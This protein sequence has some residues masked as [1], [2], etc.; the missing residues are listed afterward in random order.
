MNLGPRT[1]V[2][3]VAHG[4][5]TNLDELPAFLKAVRQG[6]APSDELVAEVRRRYDRVGGSPLWDVTQA[7]ARALEQRLGVP[8]IA[9][10]RLWHPTMLE[11]AADPRLRDCEQLCVLP[12]APFSAE[13]YCAAAT[14]ALGE[15]RAVLPHLRRLATV[16][17]YGSEPG[18]VNTHAA[19]IESELRRTANPVLVAS[20]HSVPESW[21]ETALSYQRRV[22]DCGEAIGARLGLRPLVCFQ[23]QGAR[24]G[25][26][27]GPRLDETLVRVA[28]SGRRE[29]VLVPIGFLAE[30]LETLYDLDVVAADQAR[31][32]GLDLRRVAALGLDAGLIETLATLARRALG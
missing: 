14:R 3:V 24:A 9:A 7:Q 4:T 20:A 18:L 1:G 6:R 27:V 10:M 13:E 28:R 30:H 22:L 12:L 26:W 17:P 32:L 19:R 31:Q 21:G 15:L 5:V 11:A 25:A 2:L 16:G 23:S 8:V 29:V